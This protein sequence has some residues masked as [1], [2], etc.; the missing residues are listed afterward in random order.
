MESS[1]RNARRAGPPGEQLLTA[2]SPRTLWVEDATICCTERDSPFRTVRAD[3]SYPRHHDF[4]W[5]RIR[6]VRY[7]HNT[8]CRADRRRELTDE[9]TSTTSTIHRKDLGPSP[10]APGLYGPV[11]PA[12][13]R[14]QVLSKTYKARS[15]NVS[16]G[17]ER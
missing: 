16:C 12:S 7:V 10:N 17:K 1:T 6:T 8:R 4:A 11:R 14:Q 13:R 3:E 15:T 9:H 5:L 2:R